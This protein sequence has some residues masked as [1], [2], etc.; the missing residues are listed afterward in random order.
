[1]AVYK[2]KATKYGINHNPFVTKKAP[3]KAVSIPLDKKGSI[4]F[5]F[6]P[7]YYG[8]QVIKKF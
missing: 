1:M 4:S 6:G 3:E 7:D 5:E 2:K 8:I